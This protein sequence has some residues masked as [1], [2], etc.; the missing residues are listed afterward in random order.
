MIRILKMES[1]LDLLY[2]MS[3]TVEETTRRCTSL[4][5]LTLSNREVLRSFT[6]K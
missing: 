5:K 4:G 3:E 6:R 1:P 2:W